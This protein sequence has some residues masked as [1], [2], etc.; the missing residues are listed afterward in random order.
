MGEAV[1]EPLDG[2]SEFAVPGE[3]L[4]C[5]GISKSGEGICDQD[6]TFESIIFSCS[7]GNSLKIVT[8]PSNISLM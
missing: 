5:L 4:A 8:T 6:Y 7:G 3:Q 2:K 1:S